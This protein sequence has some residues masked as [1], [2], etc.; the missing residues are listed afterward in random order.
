MQLEP[1]QEQVHDFV[2]EFAKFVGGLFNEGERALVIGGGARIDVALEHLL[3]AVT[4]PCPGGQDNLF[5]PDR[6]LGTLSAKIAAAHRFGL[7]EHNV[8][9]T[10]QMIR[11]IRNDFAHATTPITLSESAH[12]N[13]LSEIMKCMA[14]SSLYNNVRNAMEEVTQT[15]A[16]DNADNPK[17]SLL[18]ALI[19][20]GVSLEVAVWRNQPLQLYQA[21]F[22]LK[23]DNVSLNR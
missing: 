16:A 18:T 15:K 23:R 13:R 22:D 5:D 3:K 1:S 2:T 9:R 14:S 4:H 11:K 8:E 7:L 10:L 17:L 6:P 12:R 21:T 19:V 20:T